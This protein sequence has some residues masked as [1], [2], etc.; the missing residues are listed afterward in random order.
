[1]SPEEQAREIID[2]VLETVG[3]KVQDYRNLDLS[4]GLGVAVREF[5]LKTDSAD[6]MLFVDRKAAGVIE[7]KRIGMTL[8]GVDW[9][10]DKYTIGLPDNLPDPKVIAQDIAENLE[11]ALEQFNSIY[12]D[13][14]S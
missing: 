2:N 8:G 4:A 5:P 6:Y 11:A 3:W 14:G 13:L 7:A 12:G 10:S 9:Q 1:M